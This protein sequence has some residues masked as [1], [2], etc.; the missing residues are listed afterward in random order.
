MKVFTLKVDTYQ[1]RKSDGRSQSPHST[2][3]VRTAQ[4]YG[5][6]GGRKIEFGRTND[7]KKVSGVTMMSKQETETQSRSREDRWN[8][9]EEIIWT[10]NMLTAL[11]NGVKG[12]KW[13]SLIDKVHKPATLARAWEKVKAKKGAGGIDNMTIKRFQAN[14]GRY[15]QELEEQIRLGS[16]QPQAVKRVYIPKGDG[17]TRPLGIPTVKDRIVQM[18]VKMVIEPIFEKEFLPCS[19]GFRPGKGQKDALRAVDQLIKEGYYWV[20]DADIQ[21]YF[22]TIP[23]EN[24][25]KDV[26]QRIS[27]GR[28]LKLIELFLNQEIMD[29]MESWVATTGTPQGAVLSPLLANVYLHPLDC[30]MHERGYKMVRYADDSV[31]LCK[32][33]EEA[34][35]ALET[36]RTW[37]ENRDLCLHPEKT[38]IGNCME[39]G[40]GFEFLGYR[41]EA[42]RKY[43]RKKSFAK[44]KDAVR[45]KTGR[46]CGISI[47]KVVENLNPLLK[48]WY[49]YFKHAYKTTFPY[50]DGF[51]RRRLRAILRAQ[52]KR[53]SYGRTR[54]DHKRW[55]NRYF[56]SLGLFTMET[57]RVNDAA[58]R[59]R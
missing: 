30:L 45:T 18:A 54:E 47:Q 21:R 25:M 5:G 22:D 57:H 19:Y 8:W 23:H 58:C 1:K 35:E 44:F 31:I 9:V 13:F 29:E 51:I 17:K 3:E 11:V 6:K 39:E 15:L 52:E 56:A 20:V 37:T 55:P 42:G 38:H 41:F 14:E 16:Y 32:S 28:L 46:S 27:D 7:S 26:E 40:Q 4:P 10:E 24:L 50:V 33:K 2:D 12:N 53:Q 59:S 49:N 36:V 43:V 34:E 48:G